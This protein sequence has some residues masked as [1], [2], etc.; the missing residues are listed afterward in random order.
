MEPDPRAETTGNPKARPEP[1]KPRPGPLPPF[2]AGGRYQIER[3]LAEGGQK[4]VYLAR[5]TRLDREVVISLLKTELLDSDAVTRLWREAQA[6][7]RLGDHPNIVTVYDVGEEG[8]RPYIV[9]QYIPGGSVADLLQ[10]AP[11][12]QLPLDQTLRLAQQVCHA[13]AY[14]HARGFVHRDL[15]PGNVWLTEEGTAKLGDFGLA[16]GAHFSRVTMEGSLVGTVAYMAPEQALGRKAEPRSDLYSLGAMLYEMVSG[17]PPFIADQLVGVISQ[18]INTPPVAPSWHNPEVPQVLETLI[19]RLLA[20][21]PEE[22]P[23]SANEVGRALAEIAAAGPALA[24]QAVQQNSTSLARLAGG[25]FV[26]REQ[27][28]T[29]LRAGLHD[30]IAG[31]GRLLLLLGEPGSGK[32]RTAEQLATYAQLRN[33][34]VFL[35]RCYEGEGA[36]AFWPWVQILRAFVQEHDEPSLRVVMGLG[37]PDIA[38]MV[39]A[40]RERLPNLPPPPALEPEQARFRLFDSVTALLKNASKSQAM[41]IILDDLHWAD[42]PS[43]LLLEFLARELAD[44][45]LLIIGTYRDI[46]FG[47]QHPLAQTLGELAREGLGERI[48]LRGLSPQDLARFVEL[49][50]GRKPPESLVAVV[51]KETEGNPFF[52]KEIVRLLVAEGRLKRPEEVVS[53]NISLPQGVREVLSRRLDHLSEPCHRMLAIASV[54]GR[55]FDLPVLEALGELAGDRLLDLLDEALAARVI[56]EV[57]Q[58]IGRYSFYHALVRETLYEALGASRRARLHRRIGETLEKRY[59]ANQEPHLAELAHHFCQAAADSEVGKAIHYSVRAAQRDMQLLAYEDSAGHYERA[60]G[61]LRLKTPLDEDLLCELLLALGDSHKRAGNAAK[62]RENFE[63]A[64]EIARR[65]QKPEHLGHAALGVGAGVTGA[66]GKVDQLQVGLLRDALSVLPQSDSPLRARLLAQLSVALYYSP[67]MRISLSQQAVEMA[68]RVADPTAQIVA[69]YCRHLA[70]A[71][72]ES[73]EERLSVASEALGI[74]EQAGNPEMALRARYRLIL[75]LMEVG[76][77]PAVDE[78]IEAYAG[79]AEELRQP[80]Y[81]WFTPFFRATRALMEG[82]FED[83]ERLAQQALAIGRRAQDPTAMLFFGVEINLLRV[84]QGRAE[85]Q[86]GPVLASIERY[87]K[88]PAMRANLAYVYSQ[89]GRQE[90]TRREFKQ[91]AASDFTVLP[92]DGGWV[93]ALASLAYAGYFLKDTRHAERLYTLLIPYAGRNIVTGNAAVFCGPVARALALL[94]VTLSKWTQAADHFEQALKMNAKAG[95]R[96][97]LAGIQHEYAVMLLARGGPGDREKASELI[98]RA[99]ATARAL[100]MKKLAADLQGL[101]PQVS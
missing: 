38:Q 48:L 12:N 68:R 96:P 65:R 26:G 80:L 2:L 83:C 33:V 78:Q 72:T 63:Q 61:A 99:L 41:V 98:D 95:A 14:G 51:H 28:L 82:R 74:A 40:V 55:E 22:R 64:A 35:G 100:G 89:A 92:R 66:I 77:I 44:S 20:K 79:V 31:R 39:S 24:D 6:M 11:K 43:L 69:L 101:G 27:E 37:A 94:A 58:V 36:P 7:G 76:D 52:V 46:E 91:M 62:A 16:L 57:Q 23:E 21:A 70:L 25:I 54:I 56:S 50:A 13:L 67:E 73:V 3:L 34:Q 86:V 97:F 47:R 30:A 45:R 10:G 29:Q 5:D 53:W 59:E 19:L 84:L 93:V 1:V 60:Q 81:L 71:G 4:Q 32:T 8:G 75:D 18:H 88:I 17:R 90:E 42:R 87:P 15:K 49:T 9:S 85:E